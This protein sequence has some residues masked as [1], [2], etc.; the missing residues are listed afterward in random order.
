MCLRTLFFAFIAAF[1]LGLPLSADNDASGSPVF[2]FRTYTT[3]PGKLP[4][5]NKRFR[6]HTM[7]LFEKHGISNVGYWVPQDKPDTLVYIVRH[8]SRAAATQSWKAFLNDPE[9]K[10]VYQESEKNGPLLKKRPES[11]FM[12]ATDYSPIK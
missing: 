11:H 1:C 8:T 12:T 7:R 3:N 4:D 10:K 5:L 9:W 2:E 6:D